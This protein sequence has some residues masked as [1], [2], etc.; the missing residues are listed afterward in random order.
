MFTPFWVLPAVWCL[1]AVAAGFLLPELDEQSADWFPLVF[2]GG[3]EGARTLLSTIAGA[4]ISVTGLVFS[5]TIVVLQLASSQF[6]PRVLRNFLDSRTTQHT[7][8]VFAASFVYSL[9]VMRSIIDG[10]NSTELYVPQ[11]AVTVSFL[12]VVSAV[13]MFLAFIH[14]ITLSISVSTIIHEVADQIRKLLGNLPAAS[15]D[16]T[17]DPTLSPLQLETMACAKRSGYL[18]ALD[19]PALCR[20]GADYNVRIEIL[21]PRGSFVPE[22]APLA[23]ISGA[24]LLEV[25]DEWDTA[26]DQCL[27]IQRERTMQEDISYG[28]RRLVDIG[29]RALSPGA[30]DPTTAVLV[31]DELHDILGRMAVAP[32]RAAIH[33]D[34]DDVVRLVTIEWSFARY[35]DLAVDEI[36]HWGATSLQ[37]PARL[38]E[39]FDDLQRVA[40]GRHREVLAAKAAEL[41]LATAD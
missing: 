40:S 9:T 23:R 18:D 5:I 31:L 37:V 15:A 38:T 20:L 35:V 34:A 14:N 39:M 30:S 17:P 10:P 16:E 25:S 6:S 27:T 24:G 36:A 8:G 21:H 29:E 26:I 2:E 4:M 1:I 28:I 41:R 11:L 19:L 13:G 3:P 33:R 22:S 7:L 12:L 32:D